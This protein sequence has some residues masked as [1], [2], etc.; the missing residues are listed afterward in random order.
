MRV[1]LLFCIFFITSTNVVVAFTN[2]YGH[3]RARSNLYM[4]DIDIV[5]PGNKK[6]KAASGT[7]M[8]D[9]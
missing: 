7:S 9:G 1:F 3:I 6:C 2:R 5:F 4:V 8:K